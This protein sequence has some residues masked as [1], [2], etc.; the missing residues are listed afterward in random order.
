M[1]EELRYAAALP[2]KPDINDG[3]S[4]TTTHTVP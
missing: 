4:S 1:R 2:Y 3:G